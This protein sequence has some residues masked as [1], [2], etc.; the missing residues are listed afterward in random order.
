M[1]IS[2]FGQNDFGRFFPGVTTTRADY[3]IPKDYGKPYTKG[4]RPEPFT[5]GDFVSDTTYRASY[6]PVPIPKSMSA[7]IGVQTA[8]GPYKKGGVGGRI[9]RRCSECF[10]GR[11]QQRVPTAAARRL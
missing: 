4:E 7:G 10:N 8:S 1:P 5:S 11:L 9:V 3:G 2:E 6:V